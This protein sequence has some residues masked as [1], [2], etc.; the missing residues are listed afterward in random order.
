MSLQDGKECFT[1]NE[2]DKHGKAEDQK[3]CKSCLSFK[4]TE[5]YIQNSDDYMCGGEWVM[6][7][8]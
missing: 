5:K 2:Y 3:A 6:S 1:G 4:G 8:Y 7:V